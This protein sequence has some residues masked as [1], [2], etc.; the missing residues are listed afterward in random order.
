[1]KDKVYA[2]TAS[3]DDMLSVFESKLSMLKS[4]PVESSQTIQASWYDY[5]KEDTEGWVK[6]EKNG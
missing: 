3:T 2:A 4:Y 6:V 5:D 1:M